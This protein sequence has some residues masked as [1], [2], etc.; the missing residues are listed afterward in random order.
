[1]VCFIR[2]PD[3]FMLLKNQ[4]L[5]IDHLIHLRLGKAV[6]LQRHDHLSCLRYDVLSCVRKAK[7]RTCAMQRGRE[8][9]SEAMFTKD[10]YGYLNNNM[11]TDL[12]EN[13]WINIFY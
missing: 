8:M 12:T 13:R 9:S 1:M 11:F 6:A 5:N 3:I 10:R 2:N 7:T 4:S